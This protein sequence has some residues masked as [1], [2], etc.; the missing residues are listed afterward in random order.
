MEIKNLLNQTQN[1]NWIEKIQFLENNYEN[2]AF[3][4]S[5]SIEDQIIL[6]VIFKNDLNIEVFAIDTGRLPSATYEL[7]QR[8]TEKYNKPIK[9]Y[10]PNAEKIAEFVENKGINSFYNSVNFRHECCHIRKV[11]PLKKA[12][13][14]QKIWISGVRKEHNK[15]REDKDF[16]EFDANLNIIKFYPVLEFSEAQVLEYIKNEKVPYN[17]LYDQGYKSIGCDP[18]TRAVAN[19]EDARAGRWWWENEGDKECGLH[20]VNGKLVRAKDM[21]VREDKLDSELFTE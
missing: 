17:K 18:C 11:E 20:M 6:D 16:F 12:L 1:L 19:D 5:F 9:T 8:V 7:W 21:Y 13:Q 10:Y 15:N 2:V 14:G 4:T 3:S